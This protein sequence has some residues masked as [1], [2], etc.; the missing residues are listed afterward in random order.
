[1]VSL[2]VSFQVALWYFVLGAL[3][4]ASV[5]L[6]LLTTAEQVKKDRRNGRR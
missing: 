1:M 2:V 6:G 4:M 5:I 3:F